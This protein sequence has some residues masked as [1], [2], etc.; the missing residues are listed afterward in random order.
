M[1]AAG[2]AGG[3]STMIKINELKNQLADLTDQ[4]QALYDATDE[5]DLTDEELAEV[6]NLIASRDAKK[7][8]INTLEAMASSVSDEPQH[9]VEVKSNADLESYKLGAYLQDITKSTRTGAQSPRV[10]A[11]QKK[12]TTDFRAATGSSEAVPSDGGFLVG[13]DMSNEIVTRAYNSRE[14]IQR[15]NTRTVSSGSNSVTFNGVDETSRADGSRHGGV[16]GYWVAE[17]DDLTSSK[18]KFRQIKMELNKLAVL[19]YATDEVLQDAALLEQEVNAA[20]ADE[21]A[22]KIQ[23]AMIRGDGAGKPL[24][25]LNAPA[26][27]S[28]AKETG[29]TADTLVYENILKMDARKWGPSSRYIWIINQEVYPQLGQMNLAVGTGGAPVYLPNGGASEADF[30]RLAN[31]PVLEIEQASALGD[32]GDIILADMSQYRL[33]DKGGVQSAMSIHV[34]FVADEVVYRW[35]TRIDGQPLWNSALTPY[36]G[37]ATRSPF[38]TLAAR[39]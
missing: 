3:I 17:G 9:Q 14:L 21:L 18:P 19:Y 32:L 31:K 27:V 29:Q 16:R 36:K 15:A 35:I 8:K 5:R 10:A 22:F 25:I 12:V 13:S 6:K 37:S 1:G 2:N 23:D 30:S 34:E 33:I 7:D 39:A 11:Y 28:Q 26:L 20:V 38:I 24:G 4:I